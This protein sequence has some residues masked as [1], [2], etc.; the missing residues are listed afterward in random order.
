MPGIVLPPLRDDFSHIYLHFPIQVADRAA[1]QRYMFEH[2]RDVVIQH[3]NNTAD[4]PC[5]SAF[6]RDCPQARR[7]AASV[8]LL[9]TYPGY[10]R[11]EAAKNVEII[12]RFF[13]SDNARSRAGLALEQPGVL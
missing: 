6:A 4:L 7:T 9:P 2:G 1:L 11:S 10:R 3:I 8:L 5:F 12:R 13:R